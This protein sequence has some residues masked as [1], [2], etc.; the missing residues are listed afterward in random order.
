MATQTVHTN[1]I[2]H[3]LPTF[4]SS[5]KDLSAVITGANGISGQHML[6][7]LAQ[8]PERWSKIYCL[9]RRPPA[10]PGGLPANA[11]HIP[12]DFLKSPEEIGEVLKKEGVKADY[13]FFFSY[14]QV[15]PKDGAALWSNAEDMCVVNT[16]LLSN[17]LE[18][19][20]IASIKPKRIML[21]TGAK[22]YGLHLG[23]TTVPQEESDPRVMLE[24]NFY[25]PQEDYLWSYCEKH[26]IG[27]NVARPSFI[28]GAVPDAAM[29]VCFPLAVYASVQKH[30]GKPIEYP[31]D[32]T[33]W[34]MTQVQ[35]SAMLNGYLED[36]AFSWGK[37]W[38]K[39]AGWYG[40]GYERPSLKQEDYKPVELPHEAPRGFGPR[41]TLR[42]R[43]TL[44]EWAKQPEVA[45]A[46]KEL[47]EKHGL[48]DKELRDVDRIFSFTDAA[49]SWCYPI[50]FSMDKARKLG[51]HGFVDSSECILEV[52]KDFEKSKMI[53]PVPM[54]HVKFS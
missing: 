38:P 15:E 2:Y 54:V 36:S 34:E 7:V 35:S 41:G 30:L 49:L 42:F 27:W 20:P 11:V 5:L 31:S 4:D 21:Q 53:P 12:L 29:N 23:P 48:V 26:S 17:F 10:V 18:A 25:Y 28:L 50:N 47:A 3:G 46:W 39:M 37:F 19:L 22:N 52:F 24:P 9:S 40:I 44:T 51:W 32:L 45:Q 43:F 1:G 14:I 16:K 13:V 33:A 6:R 8:A